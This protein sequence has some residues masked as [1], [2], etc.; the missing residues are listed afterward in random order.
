MTAQQRQD[1]SARHAGAGLFAR[2]REYEQ[3]SLE[4][5][6]GERGRQ[7]K[8]SNWS[9]VAFRLGDFSLTCRIEQVEE[10]IAFPPYTALPGTKNWLL[11]IANVRGNLAPVADLG[12]YLFGTRTPVTARTRLVLTRFQSR[13]A[14]LVVDEVFGQRH[15]HTD[16]LVP[17]EDWDDTPLSGLV[18]QVFPTSERIWGVLKLDSLEQRSDFMNGAREI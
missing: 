17:A 12:W 11:G 15:F 9:G 1:P 13:L 5:D 2:L 4:H 3:R 10:V 8:I 7:Q 14:G 16:D 6:V 18:A